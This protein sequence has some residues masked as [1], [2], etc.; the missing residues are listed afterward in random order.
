MIVL[1]FL[2]VNAVPLINFKQTLLVMCPILLATT[3]V[4]FKVTSKLLDQVYEQ[5]DLAAITHLLRTPK[6]Y[7]TSETTNVV[8]IGIMFCV[9]HY[10]QQLD[11]I[12]LIIK[13][14]MIS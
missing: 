4:Q 2:T 14:H 1:S 11:L 7:Y 12:S 8:M 5:Q 13:K 6:E 3:S 10:L 9:A